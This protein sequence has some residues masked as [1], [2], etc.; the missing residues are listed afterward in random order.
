DR[1][2]ERLSEAIARRS[3]LLADQHSRGDRAGSGG[4]PKNAV[5]QRRGEAEM[6]RLDTEIKQ[7]QQTLHQ[8]LEHLN[9]ALPAV[10]GLREFAIDLKP[11]IARVVGEAHSITD[12]AVAAALAEPAVPVTP[13]LH[14][15][16]GRT[17]GEGASTYAVPA[18]RAHRA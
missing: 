7:L 17:P 6:K 12:A 13:D 1:A 16:T 9:Q 5:E 14:I 3:E 15:W 10:P 8:E 2:A 18:E 4:T 11:E